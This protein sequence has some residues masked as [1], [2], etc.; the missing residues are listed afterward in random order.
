MRIAVCFLDYL[1]FLSSLSLGSVQLVFLPIHFIYICSDRPVHSDWR[2][3]W[4]W[5]SGFDFCNFQAICCI[6][7]VD[8]EILFFL[9]LLR[10]IIPFGTIVAILTTTS[11]SSSR[12]TFSNIPTFPRVFFPFAATILY[13]V[14]HIIHTLFF[15]MFSFTSFPPINE[16]NI[17]RRIQCHLS[18]IYLISL[19]FWGGGGAAIIV[20]V[21]N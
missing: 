17:W 1:S 11:F 13:S 7:W 2:M 5:H 3:V 12:L 14:I 21:R 18:S 20:P 6:P 16:K 4:L 10:I 15:K 9:F 19:F 8:E